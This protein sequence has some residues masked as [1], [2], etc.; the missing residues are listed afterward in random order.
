MALPRGDSLTGSRYDRGRRAL[1]R[2]QKYGAL[3][4][5]DLV[6]LWAD[7]LSV[8]T[9][10]SRS[11]DAWEQEANTRSTLP[12]TEVLGRMFEIMALAKA[13]DERLR[14]GIGAAEPL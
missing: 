12:P 5:R 4:C 11:I 6:Q 14:K 9:K 2:S 3:T 13:A 1:T 10:M 7:S 8:R